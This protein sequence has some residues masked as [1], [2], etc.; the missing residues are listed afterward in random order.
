MKKGIVILYSVIVIAIILVSAYKDQFSSECYLDVM[1]HSTSDFY[2]YKIFYDKT[3]VLDLDGPIA[4]FIRCS[5]QRA[6]EEQY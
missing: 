1:W 2:L 3:A 4:Q 6:E 5:I